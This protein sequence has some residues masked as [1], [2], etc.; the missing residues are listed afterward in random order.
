MRLGPKMFGNG[1]PS[2]LRE[3]ELDAEEF[4]EIVNSM[5][6]DTATREIMSR[7]D[8]I[9]AVRREEAREEADRRE[10]LPTSAETSRAEEA[11]HWALLYLRDR[12]MQA[13][14]IQL[15]AR[16]TAHDISIAAALRNRCAAVDHARGRLG[17]IELDRGPAKPKD[18]LER[19]LHSRSKH[20]APK[21]ARRQAEEDAARARRR[22]AIAEEAAGWAN[23]RLA[24]A[25][26]AEHA[27]NIR[28]NAV[29]RF[30]RMLESVDVKPTK[31]QR[32]DVA[33][34]KVYSK[35]WLQVQRKIA[36]AEIAD[37]LNR[38]RMEVR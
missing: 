37:A 11:L 16:C 21:V 24:E 32:G 22:A 13:D 5:G 19:A 26:D 4:A 38:A 29:I 6:P 8:S 27:A 12:P 7:R 31:V 17:T 20:V 35:R 34:G 15:W 18:E 33:P 1:W 36:A 23:R 30:N 10:A 14:A 25:R 2:I 3:I 28:A 9:V